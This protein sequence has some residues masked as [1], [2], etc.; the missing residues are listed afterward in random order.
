MEKDKI[1][2]DGIITDFY[3]SVDDRFFYRIKNDWKINASLLFFTLSILYLFINVLPIVPGLSD[4]YF[5]SLFELIKNNTNLP[6][7]EFNFWVKWGLGFIVSILIFGIS[8]LF[9]RYWSNKESQKAI[10]V[11]QMNFCYAYTLRKELKSY[12]INDNPIHLTKSIDYLKKVISPFNEVKF[13]NSE[14][15]TSMSLNKFRDELKKQFEW[16]Q[17]TEET[18]NYI[19]NLSSINKKLIIRF[20]QKEKL[21]DIVPAIDFLTLY[22]F[23]KIKPTVQ[24]SE[25]VEIKNFKNEYFKSFV[26]E[27]GK[28]KEIEEDKNSGERK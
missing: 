21:E 10:D 1:L 18:N 11:K 20:K 28:I 2:I 6:L 17:F 27:V 15:E 3:N 13:K 9:F 19:D 25:N 12:L 7:N 23:A 22:E 4:K 16:M 14:K 24:N 8:F 5:F 26:N